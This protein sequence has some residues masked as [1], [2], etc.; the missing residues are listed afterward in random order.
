[1]NVLESGVSII[2][3]T[4]NEAQYGINFLA[5]GLIAG[6]YEAVQKISKFF[7]YSSAVVVTLMPS[8]S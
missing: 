8:H 3:S 5:V 2:K 1:M 4:C 7:S 6:K